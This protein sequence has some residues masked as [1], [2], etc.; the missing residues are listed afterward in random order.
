[1][2]EI[3]SPDRWHMGH[4]RRRMGRLRGRLKPLASIL[5]PCPVVM[6]S[7]QERQGLVRWALMETQAQLLGFSTILIMAITPALMATGSIN[8]FVLL[9]FSPYEKFYIGHLCLKHNIISPVQR[10]DLAFS[11]GV[12]VSVRLVLCSAMPR[13]RG[14]PRWGPTYYSM[15]G[16][17]NHPWHA[18]QALIPSGDHMGSSGQNW[19]E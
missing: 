18:S 7:L 3:V 19:F 1:M 2:V 9:V 13:E 8:A 5:P 12:S 11:T 4:T 6:V 15:F 16:K 10:H 14:K 17:H